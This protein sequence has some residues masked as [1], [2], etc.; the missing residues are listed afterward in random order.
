MGCSIELMDLISQLIEAIKPPNDPSFL[1]DE[2]RKT[3]DCIERCLKSVCQVFHSEKEDEVQSRKDMIVLIA[4]LYRLAALTYLERVGRGSP[5]FSP[6][7]ET[8]LDDAAVIWA[9]LDMCERPFPLFIIACEARSESH[10]KLA[11]DLMRKQKE[12]RNCGN[13]KSTRS[14]VQA[15]W[16]QDDLHEETDLSCFAKYSA[17]ISAYEGIPSFA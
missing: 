1:D 7:V 8:Y 11:L 5:R 15:A 14:L 6:I 16:V 12:L 4:E 13:L 2:H 3:L 9:K 17:V 10:R